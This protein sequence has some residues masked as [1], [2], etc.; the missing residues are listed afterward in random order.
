MVPNQAVMTVVMYEK[1][2]DSGKESLHFIPDESGTTNLWGQTYQNPFRSLLSLETHH[3]MIH[4]QRKG[5]QEI[6]K[7][8]VFPTPPASMERFKPRQGARI[9]ITSRICPVDINIHQTMT[10]MISAN[11]FSAIIDHR[12]PN[13]LH[14]INWGSS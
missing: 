6:A 2:G 14:T 5:L 8:G 13:A 10:Q 12:L 4:A 1:P 3:G 7:H 9:A 11:K